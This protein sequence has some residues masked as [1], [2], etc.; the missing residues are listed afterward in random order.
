[1]VA[2][3]IPTL[4]SLFRR[5]SK[6]QARKPNFFSSLSTT[7]FSKKFGLHRDSR[8]ER[9]RD[10]GHG[11]S[12]GSTT[13]SEK[14]PPIMIHTAVSDSVL[15]SEPASPSTR[16]ETDHDSFSSPRANR[17]SGDQKRHSRYNRNSWHGSG[18]GTKGYQPDMELRTG[19]TI[20]KQLDRAGEISHYE[21]RALPS[22]PSQS[23]PPRSN[24]LSPSAFSFSTSGNIAEAEWT[25]KASVGHGSSFQYLQ[26]QDEVSPINS[27]DGS[28]RESIIIEK[29]SA[30]G[31][32]EQ[33]EPNKRSAY[34]PT[35][36]NPSFE[37]GFAGSDRS[38]EG[39]E[40]PAEKV[41]NTP[42]APRPNPGLKV[43]RPTPI[44]P[45][46][47]P[48]IPQPQSPLNKE[49]VDNSIGF[50]SLRPPEQPYP[51][52]NYAQYRHHSRTKSA[53]TDPKSLASMS[54]SP[55]PISAVGTF[56]SMSPSPTCS[57]S[58]PPV[59]PSPPP[60]L[61]SPTPD[62]SNLQPP[63]F[64]R[65]GDSA[66]STPKALPRLTIPNRT[67]SPTSF[68]HISPTSSESEMDT[69]SE[70]EQ[71]TVQ[72]AEAITVRNMR[73]S[74]TYL[75][76]PASA[77]TPSTASKTP[78]NRTFWDPSIT[79]AADAPQNN[80]A[81]NPLQDATPVPHPPQLQNPTPPSSPP[82]KPAR[83]QPTLQ[84]PQSKPLRLTPSPNTHLFTLTDIWTPETPAQSHKRLSALVSPMSG[85][86]TTSSGNPWSPDSNWSKLGAA[87]IPSGS[88][89]FSPNGV[90]PITGSS[91][92]PTFGALARMASVRSSTT[93]SSTT[94]GMWGRDSRLGLIGRAV[95]TP[96]GM[97]PYPSNPVSPE[98]ISATG[99]RG[100]SRMDGWG[101]GWTFTLKKERDGEG[102]GYGFSYGYD[103]VPSGVRSGGERSGKEEISPTS[104]I[105]PW[106]RKVEERRVS[107]S[108]LEVVS[109]GNGMEGE[110][111][112]V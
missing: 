108:T 8:D 101:D 56:I 77:I 103:A 37:F 45:D 12:N 76:S 21:S 31:D 111:G 91:G 100:E 102:F 66:P 36:F 25:R 93:A 89:S 23:P 47:S 18:K 24:A 82:Y 78:K 81:P 44:G 9:D 7:G 57:P 95:T 88:S 107:Y 39:R 110:F 99:E 41:A 73:N 35:G 2:A 104:G 15:S 14:K 92:S 97:G 59:F 71:S 105:S 6:R 34:F 90:S 85:I 51:R 60:L 42:L 84:I 87:Y 48:K 50:S 112:R 52:T 109:V 32:A 16:L 70:M 1:M 83:P 69:D 58:P 27:D 11:G 54:P 55:R 28:A 75:E 64:Q 19:Y 4:R 98:P 61:T 3:S 68:L 67:P 94:T 49:K 74:A 96:G 17:T 26:T 30:D 79:P 106:T 63:S 5:R 13:T 46:G 43:Y 22:L 20:P 33:N 38:T 53:I 10:S 80:R 86:S 40:S 29:E 72:K 65:R 62:F